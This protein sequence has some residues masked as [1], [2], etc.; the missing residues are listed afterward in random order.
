MGKLLKKKS[1]DVYR[2]GIQTV[3]RDGIVE[4]PTDAIPLA[5]NMKMPVLA[6]NPSTLSFDLGSIDV[7]V[8]AQKVDVKVKKV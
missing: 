6:K 8:Y 5:V 2:I 7:V 4:L 3:S 1:L